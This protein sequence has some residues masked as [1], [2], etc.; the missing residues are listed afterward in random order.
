MSFGPYRDLPSKAPA[1]FELAIGNPPPELADLGWS[2]RNP[3]EVTKDPWTYQSF[4]IQS[5][6]EF[7]VA[8]HGYVASHSGWF[9][10]R[11][12]CYL[13]CGRPVLVQDTGFSHWL[14]TGRGVIA[15]ST[16]DQAL[17]GVEEI[18]SHYPRHCVSAREIAEAYFDSAK[19]LNQLLAAVHNKQWPAKNRTDRIGSS[20]APNAE[21]VQTPLAI[22]RG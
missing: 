18:N 12:A 15:Y 21:S 11:S 20:S 10:E 14:P 16:P 19:V 13:A 6:A 1:S 22:P 8:K 5:K 17:D 3:L 4:I 9:S 2:L 7:S